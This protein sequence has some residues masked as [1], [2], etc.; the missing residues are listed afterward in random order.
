MAAP[1]DVP[2][3]QGALAARV[4]D[5]RSSPLPT[6]L[7]PATAPPSA[8]RRTAVPVLRPSNLI[9]ESATTLESRA[10]PPNSQ[11]PRCRK[12]INCNHP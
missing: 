3:R 7:R 9:P 10:H 11:L 4:D 2:R 12:D 8:P 6:T 1:V 5:G